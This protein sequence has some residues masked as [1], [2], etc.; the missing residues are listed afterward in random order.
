MGERTVDQLASPKDKYLENPQATGVRG[1]HTINLHQFARDGVVLLGH[2]RDGRD[3]KISLAPDLM[4]SLA[5]SD[6]FEVDMLKRIDEVII[7]SGLNLP[8]ERQPE[9]RDGYA[10]EII[11]EL[12]LKTAGIS[13]IIWAMGYHFDYSLVKLPVV[14]EDGFPLQKRGVTNYPG[15]YFIGMPWLFTRQ[16]NLLYGV[17]EDAELIAARI[18]GK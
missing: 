8:E 7:Q 11:S 9:L 2:V 13:S 18:A 4:E 10:S 5:K 14:D 15:L 12:D 6:Q 3:G 1:G 17:G 16:S